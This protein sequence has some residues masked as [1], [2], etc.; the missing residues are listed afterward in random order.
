[1]DPKLANQSQLTTSEARG[2]E[3]KRHTDESSREPNQTAED[4]ANDNFGRELDRVHFSE[5]R[6]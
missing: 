5:L 6:E 3:Q 4:A 2:K 1:M